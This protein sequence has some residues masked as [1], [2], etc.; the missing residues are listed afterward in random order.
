M[1]KAFQIVVRK[2]KTVEAT[3]SYLLSLYSLVDVRSTPD[4]VKEHYHK[5]IDCKDCKRPGLSW[6]ITKVRFIYTPP[7]MSSD[8]YFCLVVFKG[9]YIG[10]KISE[11]L[12]LKVTFCV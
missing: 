9:S 2:I 6:N 4:N 7:V 10:V 8:S 5:L 11:F 12:S 1:D 3:E